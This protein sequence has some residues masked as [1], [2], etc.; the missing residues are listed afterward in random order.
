MRQVRTPFLRSCFVSYTDKRGLQ[1]AKS[2]DR[3]DWV[4]T[5]AYVAT[6]TLHVELRS[7]IGSRI[8]GGT[9]QEIN[10]QLL[11]FV[12]SQAVRSQTPEVPVERDISEAQWKRKH[13]AFLDVQGVFGRWR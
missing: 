9:P 4:S 3:E 13:L 11:E 12:C 7:E 8:S 1:E 2:I 6:L 5:A 10:K